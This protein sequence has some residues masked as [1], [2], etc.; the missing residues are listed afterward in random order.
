MVRNFIQET[1]QVWIKSKKKSAKKMPPWSGN[2]KW[3]GN[4]N[5]C[6]GVKMKKEKEKKKIYRK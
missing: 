2:E 6:R 3:T 4:G 1:A 5:V